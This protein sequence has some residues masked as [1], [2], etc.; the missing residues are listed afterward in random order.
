MRIVI[1]LF[2]F[3]FQTAAFSFPNHTPKTALICG[4]G[5]FIGHHLVNRYKSEGYWVRGVDIKYPDFEHS[6]ADEF[7]I[8]DLRNPQ[9]VDRAFA[10]IDGSFDEVIQLAADM[11][12]M[13]FIAFHEAQILYSNALINLNVL[14]AARKYKAKEI[15]YSSSACIYPER[16][17]LDPNHPDCREDTAYPAFP[18]T[19]YGWEKLFSERLYEAYRKDHGMKICIARLHN[20]FGPKGTWEGGREKAPA[21]LCRKIAESD[22]DGYISVWGDGEQTRSFLY[23]DEC[24]EGIRRM[25]QSDK[26]LPIMNLGSDEM[27]SINELCSIIARHSHKNI[28]LQHI[29][30]PTGVRGRCSYNNLMQQELGWTP[31]SSLDSG[32]AQTYDWIEKQVKMK[33]VKEK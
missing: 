29:D 18:D 1:F 30:G 2:I 21:A 5:G 24:V 32:I 17:Q 31:S 3:S 23:I 27:V 26:D 33:Q 13:G 19:E 22:A 10:S 6:E 4:A 12:G 16:N 11:G 15:F 25:M 7:I 28:H 8:A 20:V 14:E 9:E